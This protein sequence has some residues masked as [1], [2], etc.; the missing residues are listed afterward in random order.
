ML[1]SLGCYHGIGGGAAGDAGADAGE[2]AGEDAS[3]S[4]TSDDAG[5]PGVLD[6]NCVA[7]ARIWKLTP[8]QYDRTVAAMI[9]G[10]PAVGE[11]LAASL[12]GDVKIFSNEA[13]VFEMTETHVD[14]L[15]SIS[16]SVADAALADPGALHS[17]LPQGIDDTACIE[18]VLDGLLPKAFRRPP[19]EQ[20]RVHYREFFESQRTQYGGA[21]ALW[22]TVRMVLMSPD[23][24]YRTEL[25]D[26]TNEDGITALTS[27]ERASA[28]AYLLLDGPPDDDLLAAAAAD[29]LQTTEQLEAQVLRLLGT[30]EGIRGIQRFFTEYLGSDEV[31]GAEKDTEL[32]EAFTPQFVEAAAQ[33]PGRFV[34]YVLQEDDA[35]LATLLSADY[36]VVDPVLAEFYGAAEPPAQGFAPTSLP[37]DQRSGL[38]TQAAFLMVFATFDQS[39]PIHRG[40]FILESLL[41]GGELALPDD[42]DVFPPPADPESTQRERLAEHSENPACAG[43]H[44]LMDPLGFAFEHYDAIGE[45]RDAENGKPVDASGEVISTEAT[46]GSFEDAIELTRMLAESPDVQACVMRQVYQYVHGR[47]T[48]EADECA[49]EPLDE[50]F[51]A[52]QGDLVDLVVGLVT[53]ENFTVRSRG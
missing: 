14:R 3:N 22:Q 49:L 9:P 29:Q 39:D 10:A 6:G 33:E 12:P 26:Q 41:C 25:G 53:Q 48:S 37:A 5:E 19:T 47:R 13:A 44:D 30:E 8:R 2:D 51:A 52:S 17:C 20:E 7:P 43:C 21:D 45:W 18:Q 16:S 35:K 15:F 11:Q 36:S 4:D 27:Y 24:L 23:F 28:L 40:K 42:A 31:L 1:A 46:N 50:R 32:F 34:A 38:L